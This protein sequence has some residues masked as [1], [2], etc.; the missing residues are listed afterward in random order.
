M[1]YILNKQF[2]LN[3][4]R[5][6]SK[7]VRRELFWLSVVASALYSIC[8]AFCSNFKPHSHPDVILSRGLFSLSYPI[9]ANF[10]AGKVKCLTYM[11]C[12]SVQQTR[13]LRLSVLSN[14]NCV[15]C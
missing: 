10:S 5:V 3:I 13:S 1:R 6:I 15:I 11:M 4:S 12:E 8:I 9:A 2:L 7:S 14:P